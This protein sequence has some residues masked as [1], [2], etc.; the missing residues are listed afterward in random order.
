[1]GGKQGGRLSKLDIF[2]QLSGTWHT[3][4]YTSFIHFYEGIHRIRCTCHRVCLDN[5]IRYALHVVELEGNIKNVLIIFLLPLK[6]L[7]L[8]TS[9]DSSFSCFKSSRSLLVTSNQINECL[10]STT[11]HSMSL[12]IDSHNYQWTNV[13]ISSFLFFKTGIV[14][15]HF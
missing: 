10:I 12:V 15:F 11:F 8:T 9:L 1:M 3:S 2:Q 5:R 14:F 13:T 6:A 4:L 7:I